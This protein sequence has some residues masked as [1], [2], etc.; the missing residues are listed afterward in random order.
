M[1]NKIKFF[2][3]VAAFCLF[4][5]IAF[6]SGE[7]EAKEECNSSSKG[8]KIGYETGK[9]SLWSDPE[10]HKRECNN[11]AGMIGEVPPCWNEGFVDGY[12]GK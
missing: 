1:K 3:T 12:N 4:L 11:G 10:T 5:F 7:T 9:T 6:A 8:Y 2:T